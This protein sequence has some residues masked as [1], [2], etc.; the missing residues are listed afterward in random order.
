MKLSSLDWSI[1]IGYLVFSFGLAALYVRRASKGMAEFFVSGRSLPWWLLGTSMV[2]TTFSTDTPNLVTNLVR[3]NGVAGNWV[4][5]AFLVTGMMTVF[6]Y[7][8]LWRRSKVLTDLEFYEIRY[9]GKSAAVVRGFRAIYLGFFFNIV[10]MASVTLAAAKIANILFGW[11]R[12]ETVL[13]CSVIVVSFSVMSGLWGV[14]VTDLVQFIMAM[15]GAV[16]AAYYGLN[17]EAVGGLSGLVSKLDP[18]TLN[19]LPDFGNWELTLSIL[20]IP[21][22]IQWWSVWY[23]GAEPGGGS[24]I[25]QRMLAAKDEKHSMAATLWFNVA[26]YGLRPWP[27]ILV[28]LASILVYPSLADIQSAFPHVSQ[29]LIGNDIAYPAMLKFLPSGLLG[30]M[31]ASLMAAYISTMDTHLNWGASYLVHDLYK[32]FIKPVAS[33]KH[34]VLVARIVTALLMVLAALTMLFFIAFG[35]FIMRKAGV[36]FPTHLSLISSVS[37]TTIVWLI[38]TY[39]TE[40]T[41]K[42]V[43]VKFYKLV[44]PFGKGWDFIRKE[45]GLEPSSDSIAHAFLGWMFGI[46]LVYSALFG[47][48]SFLYG[49]I[50]NGIFCLIPFLISTAGLVWLLPKFF[51]GGVDK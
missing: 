36:D 38:V 4:W 35:F 44:R 45:T 26:H 37:L 22:T 8:R 12:I 1:I 30:V 50:A 42:K 13:F 18:G 33:E 7:A 19:L 15:V 48:G 27:W 49:K 21:L 24:Y 46:M 23:P 39:A 28:A 31:V 40:P 20:I 16:A 51:K 11:S 41:D 14:V 47:T 3:D 10:I 43:L 5:W 6:F 2:A 29:D 25:A 34:Y 9:S 17:H 32:R